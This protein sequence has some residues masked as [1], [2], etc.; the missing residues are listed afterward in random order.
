MMAIPFLGIIS[1]R[2]HE[3]NK[4][5]TYL[6]G[7]NRLRSSLNAFSFNEPLTAKSMDLFNLLKWCADIGFDAVDITG[8]YFDGYPEIPEAS[9]LYR[10]K[11]MAHALGIEISGIGVRND[12]TIPDKNL[13]EKEKQRVFDWINVA[14]DLGA[15]VL[16]VF[17]GQEKRDGF[18]REQI[19]EWMLEDLHQCVISAESK[20]VII[21]IQN[22]NDFLQTSDQVIEF[23]KA[24][25]NP[26][27][28]LILDTGSYRKE[29]PYQA[30]ENTVPYAVNWQLKEN[31][32]ID[33]KEVET[34]LAKVFNII[35]KSSYQGYLPIET[36][37]TGDPKQKIAALYKKVMIEMNK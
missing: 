32:F 34:D 36:L 28:G 37:G 19:K 26:W 15:P 22:H 6:S 11:R 16:R 17:A 20:G 2:L 31:I 23:M 12:F 29:D 13:R 5:T 3:T 8:Y 4:T 10:I 24:I 35:R 21:G 30:I 1:N 14:A 18:T 9:Y 25:T 7:R 33:G 27:F